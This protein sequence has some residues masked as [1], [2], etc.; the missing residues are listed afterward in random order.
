MAI[1]ALF[2]GV[3][4]RWC[5]EGLDVVVVGSGGRERGRGREG[6]ME[7]GGHGGTGIA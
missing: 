4:V 1:I 6:G 7:S 5:H 2:M 3:A